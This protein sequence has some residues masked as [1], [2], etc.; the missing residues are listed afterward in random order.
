MYEFIMIAIIVFGVI[1]AVMIELQWRKD[2]K[3]L[4]RQY[5][6]EERRIDDLEKRILAKRQVM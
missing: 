2:I 6:Q 5:E 3:K 4:N 1:K